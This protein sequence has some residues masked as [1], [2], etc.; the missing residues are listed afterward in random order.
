[1]PSKVIGTLLVREFAERMSLEID[2][3]EHKNQEQEEI[4]EQLTGTGKPKGYIYIHPLDLAV[5]FDKL[6][7]INEPIDVTTVPYDKYDLIHVDGKVYR[8]SPF[9]PKVTKKYD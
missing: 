3:L 1:M 7:V 4:I 8:Q 9:I 5:V 2:W 6:N